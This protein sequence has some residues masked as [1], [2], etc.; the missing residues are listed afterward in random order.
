MLF[1]VFFVEECGAVY[2]YKLLTRGI[3]TP[4]RA[5]NLRQLNVLNQPVCG[6]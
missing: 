2:A 3:G 4:I 1:Q 6:T 5:G